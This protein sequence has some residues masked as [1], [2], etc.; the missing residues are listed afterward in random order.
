M[1]YQLYTNASKKICNIWLI[2]L[3]INWFVH[4]PSRILQLSEFLWTLRFSVWVDFNNF[5]LIDATDSIKISSHHHRILFDVSL[6]LFHISRTLP[7]RICIP[8]TSPH[9]PCNSLNGFSPRKSHQKLIPI[10]FI[11]KWELY[12]IFNL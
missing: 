5:L 11:N 8:Y 1:N 7:L 4:D 6:N 10:F 2:C 9:R 12:S 3:E